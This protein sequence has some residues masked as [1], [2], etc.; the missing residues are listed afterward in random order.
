MS[1]ITWTSIALP[2]EVSNIGDVER[3]TFYRD[4][5]ILIDRLPR[6]PPGKRLPTTFGRDER[7]GI[8]SLPQHS[9][10]ETCFAEVS[11]LPRE[12]EDDSSWAVITEA[13]R[14]MNDDCFEEDK[15]RELSLI[16]KQYRIVLSLALTR[17]EMNTSSSTNATSR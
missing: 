6:D 12:R 2:H 8:Y 5:S 7:L 11:F 4:C 16:G 3:E 10:Q 9:V 17:S 1:A 14:E 13:F 15:K